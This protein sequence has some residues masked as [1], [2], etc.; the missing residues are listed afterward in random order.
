M[1]M[2]GNQIGG[3]SGRSGFKE[4]EGSKTIIARN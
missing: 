2:V 1:P 3:M 4:E